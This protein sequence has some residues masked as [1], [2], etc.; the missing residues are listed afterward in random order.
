MFIPIQ[1]AGTP[2]V[3]INKRTSEK[4]MDVGQ[5]SYWYC[6]RG[7]WGGMVRRDIFEAKLPGRP[8]SGFLQ[9]QAELC[10][11]FVDDHPR[12]TRCENSPGK[13]FR[14]NQAE[15]LCWP[16]TRKYDRENRDVRLMA[17]DATFPG[18]R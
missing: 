6:N 2:I 9:D 16:C 10:A 15:Y 12:C 1:G 7:Y 17:L 3:V 11:D 14:D 4:S 8:S 18:D 5:G 13:Y